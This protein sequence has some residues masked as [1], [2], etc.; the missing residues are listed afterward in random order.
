MFTC[1]KLGGTDMKIFRFSSIFCSHGL[2]GA[3][4]ATR[5]GAQW[6]TFHCAQFTL[7]CQ[8]NTF[9]GIGVIEEFC[10]CHYS[11]HENK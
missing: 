11:C 9:M 3:L 4:W 1:T 6:A 8:L 2:G 10:S 7:L 5:G